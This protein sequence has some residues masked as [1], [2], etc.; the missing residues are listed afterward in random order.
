MIQS[1][2]GAHGQQMTLPSV[3]LPVVAFDCRVAMASEIA[4]EVLR[5]SNEGY[6]VRFNNIGTAI[7][8]DVHERTTDVGPQL[9]ARSVTN[10]QVWHYVWWSEATDTQY[11]SRVSDSFLVHLD[12]EDAGTL[13]EEILTFLACISTEPERYVV[14]LDREMR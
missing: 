9:P 2:N 1:F 6:K 3:P 13:L 10:T 4:A 14:F 5:L 12:R 11:A 7:T 8:V